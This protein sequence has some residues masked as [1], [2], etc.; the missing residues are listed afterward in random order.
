MRQ[1][2]RLSPRVSTGRV[3]GA[4]GCVVCGTPRMKH[5]SLCSAHH[6]SR[7][8]ELWEERRTLAT[9]GTAFE[10]AQKRAKHRGLVFSIT[11]EM[12][13]RRFDEQGGLCYWFGIPM[14]GDP[15]ARVTIDRLDSGRGYSPDNVVLCS[16]AANLGRNKHTTDKWRALLDAMASH[17]APYATEPKR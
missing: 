4:E 13:R 8:R 15:L 9:L 12:M 11:I 16:I 5:R 14:T 6:L 3:S 10:L 2:Q 7:R 1:G 17:R